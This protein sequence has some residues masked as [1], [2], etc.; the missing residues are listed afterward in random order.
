MAYD[1]YIDIVNTVLSKIG[2]T[3][4]DVETIVRQA[5][6]DCM[7]EIC[8]AYN[9]SWLYSDTSFITVAPYSEGTV[10]VTEGS[11]NIVGSQTNFT[12][13]MVNRKFF[14]DN[15][16]YVILSVTDTTH[17]TLKTN[18]A[19]VS[20]S[21]SYKIYQ[22]EYDLASDVGNILSV[23]QEYYPQK[24]IGV[25]VEYLDKYYP[26]R[27]DFGYPYFYCKL[28]NNKIALYPIPNQARNIYYRYKKIVSDMVN[29]SDVPVIPEQYRY[30]LAKGALYMTAKSLD[31][32]DIGK[33]YQVEYQQAI[34]RI[35][36][37]DK[38]TDERIVKG[39]YSDLEELQGTFVGS[40]YPLIPL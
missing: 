3:D 29:D 16:T 14:C 8:Q 32:P 36:N 18:Y 21:Y 23:R 7:Q 27:K 25:N 39:S 5:V 26:M 17:L 2:V 13:S 9:F 38:E 31:M 40:N 37:D 19:G 28:N 20:G 11:P 22:D 15:S 10:T 24:L 35:I 34:A 33:D 6:N 1:T 12:S 4:D 30:V